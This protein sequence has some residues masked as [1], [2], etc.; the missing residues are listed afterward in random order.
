MKVGGATLPEVCSLAIKDAA[1]FFDSLELSTEQSAIAERILFEVRRR[2]RFMVEVGL[3]YLTLDRLASTLSGGE[4]Q[5]IQLATNSH[6]RLQ[7]L[8]KTG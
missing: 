7:Q 1:V 3:D 8:H 2:L 6:L 4:A 5:R